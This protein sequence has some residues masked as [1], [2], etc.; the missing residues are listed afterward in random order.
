MSGYRCCVI[1][2]DLADSKPKNPDCLWELELAVVGWLQSFLVCLHI[3]PQAVLPCR[4]A[5]G[6]A[7]G[8]E[9]F[10]RLSRAAA[11]LCIIHSASLLPS[12]SINSQ[13]KK[14]GD[15]LCDQQGVI[16]PQTGTRWNRGTSGTE[17]SLPTSLQA[18]VTH[19]L[20]TAQIHFLVSQTSWITLFSMAWEPPSSFIRLPAVFILYGLKGMWWLLSD[21]F[22]GR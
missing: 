15:S 1:W 18:P 22:P 5:A 9:K 14:A 21:H 3:A 11:K 19:P 4:E 17:P 2:F 10:Y 7:K 8:L 16:Q 12:L 13:R 6:T 20:S